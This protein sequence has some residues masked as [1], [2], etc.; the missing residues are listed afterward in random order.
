MTVILARLPAGA[1]RVVARVVHARTGQPLDPSRA[2]FHRVWRERDLV[3]GGSAMPIPELSVGQV[4]ARIKPGRWR[5]QVWVKDIGV[6]EREFQVGEADSQI[7][8]TVE[9]GERGSIL[10]R[11]ILKDV[12][13]TAV[14]ERLSIVTIPRGKRRLSL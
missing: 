2:R 11:V 13:A 6:A 9:I 8:L 7:R 3:G 14:P 10:G 4:A 12:P 5:I 1:A